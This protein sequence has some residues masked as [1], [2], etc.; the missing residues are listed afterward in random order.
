MNGMKTH[1][2]IEDKHLLV[3]NEKVVDAD[4][5]VIYEEITCDSS[6]RLPQLRIASD[7]QVERHISAAAS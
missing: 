1:T 7:E 3:T 2:Y 4:G 5:K 6:V